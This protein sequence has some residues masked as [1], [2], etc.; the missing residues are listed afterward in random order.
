MLPTLDSV[1]RRKYE[2]WRRQIFQKD[3][4]FFSQG[5]NLQHILTSKRI[6]VYIWLEKKNKAERK[7]LPPPLT[8]TSIDTCAFVCRRSERGTFNGLTPSTLTVASRVCFVFN[9]HSL[10]LFLSLSLSLTPWLLLSYIMLLSSSTC[11][12][13]SS[14]TLSW[15]LETKSIPT[16]KCND[17]ARCLS[18]CYSTSLVFNR[19]GCCSS[20]GN[21]C[22]HAHILY[23]HKRTS[24]FLLGQSYIYTHTHT[25]T[26]VRRV[27]LSLSVEYK[28]F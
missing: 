22:T 6:S 10:S 25:H 9:S 8:S 21:T 4:Y 14:L 13:V 19:D 27:L 2:K 23:P 16:G 24:I 28:R 1:V 11:Q 12:R 15:P 20:S 5:N 3:N 7:S 18:L 17:Q 26:H